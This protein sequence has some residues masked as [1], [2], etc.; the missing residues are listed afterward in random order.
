MHP[1]QQ[2]PRT[3]PELHLWKVFIKA[4]DGDLWQI[5]ER[6]V[7]AYGNPFVVPEKESYDE[8]A[9][10]ILYQMALIHVASM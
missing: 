6:W 7:K 4:Y 3:Y 5:I 2:P 1:F 9:Q 10:R 8:E